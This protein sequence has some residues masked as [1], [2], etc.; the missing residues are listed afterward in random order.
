MFA[1]CVF[2]ERV[3]RRSAANAPSLEELALASPRHQQFSMEVGKE[4][5]AFS[6][7]RSR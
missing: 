2:A 5:S 3:I 6:H 4:H 1:A 7:A